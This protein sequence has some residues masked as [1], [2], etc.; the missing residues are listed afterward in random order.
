MSYLFIDTT[1]A[2]PI[3]WKCPAVCWI[4][5]SIRAARTGL[6]LLWQ[7]AKF[8]CL[9]CS[10]SVADLNSRFWLSDAFPHIKKY[11]FKYMPVNFNEY[12]SSNCFRCMVLGHQILTYYRCREIYLQGFLLLLFGWFCCCCLFLHIKHV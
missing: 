8:Y 2:D 6:L 7:R 4:F 9:S 3:H 10:S 1:L 12:P 11:C 5:C